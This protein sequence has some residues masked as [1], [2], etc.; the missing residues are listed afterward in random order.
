MAP[1]YTL[2]FIQLGFIV[3]SLVLLRTS[4]VEF[5]LS[6][7]VPTVDD[8]FSI[9]LTFLG[10]L[11]I[12][13]GGTL[14]QS[15]FGQS[16]TSGVRALEST[17]LIVAIAVVSVTLAPVA[18]EL[19]FRGIIQGGLR[20]R[21]G[22]VVSILVASGLFGAAHALNF[23]GTPLEVFSAVAIIAVVSIPYAISYE[24]T[25]NLTIPIASHALYNLTIYAL[26]FSIY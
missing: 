18:E 12:L 8:L 15:H 4:N 9:G 13:V 5:H 17:Q 6:V 7:S 11:S 26:I 19:L 23:S 24:L 25:E 22:A 20:S 1:L 2:F 10:S 16:P 14:V 21:F 3:I